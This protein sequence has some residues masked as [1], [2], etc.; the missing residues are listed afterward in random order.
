M[1]QVREENLGE[2]R[3][4]QMMEKLHFA[5]D[6][7]LDAKFPAQRICRAEILT[8]DGR[9]F[10]SAECEPRGEAKENIGVDWLC[11]KFRR[12]SAPVL[13]QEGQEKLIDLITGDEDVPVRTIVD[14]ANAYLK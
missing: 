4:V 3:V 10:V 13:T 12:I 5:V 2:E 11:D 7:A 14:T 9:K 1:E 8:K 6:E